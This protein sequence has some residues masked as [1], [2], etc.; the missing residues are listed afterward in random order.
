M[1]FKTIQ[2]ILFSTL[3]LATPI[4]PNKHIF[5]RGDTASNETALLNG[6]TSFN[7]TVVINII[8][9]DALSSCVGATYEFF[10]ECATVAHAADS[11]SYAVSGQDFQVGELGA[12]IAL[13]A[14]ESGDFKYNVHHFPSANAGQGTRNMQM[15]GYNLQYARSIP[16]LAGPLANI[17]TANSTANLSSD[18]LDQ[19]L[20]LVADDKY[21]WGSAG[22]YLKT[23]CPG[24]VRNG[25]AGASDEA[26]DAYLSCV[27][28]NATNT[29]LQG[30][31]TRAK[32]AL[33]LLD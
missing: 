10:N 25:L 9:P 26:W 31:W 8:S 1:L 23:Q 2:V 27:G 16:E 15:P 32:A 11:I 33:N 3:A 22:W 17:T 24:S 21:T 6:T 20:N 19:I 28:E 7:S 5:G 14:F 18:A 12:I 29:K 13:M 4:A 30:Y